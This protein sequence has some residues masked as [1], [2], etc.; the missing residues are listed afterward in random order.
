MRAEDAPGVSSGPRRRPHATGDRG[1]AG[2]RVRAVMLMLRAVPKAVG[3]A[4][5]GD[6]CGLRA[7]SS[8]AA[9]ARDPRRD[10]SSGALPAGQGAD[11]PGESLWDSELTPATAP[12]EP[13]TPQDAPQSP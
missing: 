12:R 11:A 6:P 1:G 3:G 13:A 4:S 9:P 8:G 5:Q 2:P 7:E 10:H